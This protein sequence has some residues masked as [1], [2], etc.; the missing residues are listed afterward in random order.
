MIADNLSESIAICLALL[1]F[2]VFVLVS[3]STGYGYY[4]GYKDGYTRREVSDE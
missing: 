4:Q 3:V 1:I 2:G